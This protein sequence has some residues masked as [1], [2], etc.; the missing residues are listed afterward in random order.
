MRSMVNTGAFTAGKINTNSYEM[1]W[2]ISG[3][4]GNSAVH[5]S[6][7]DLSKDTER[8]FKFVDGSD[9]AGQ[10]DISKYSYDS[11]DST[12]TDFDSDDWPP[13]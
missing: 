12:K 8:G 5:I 10:I 9:K 7:I 13:K 11:K 4:T 6:N 1:D 2:S 3:L